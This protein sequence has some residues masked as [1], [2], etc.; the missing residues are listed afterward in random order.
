MLDQFYFWWHRLDEIAMS[1]HISMQS[2]I[3]QEVSD[4]YEIYT[5]NTYYR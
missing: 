2:A 4:I 5:M 3:S 1:F